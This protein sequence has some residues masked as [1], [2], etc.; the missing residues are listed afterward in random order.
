MHRLFDLFHHGA[1]LDG[2]NAQVSVRNFTLASRKI[3]PQTATLS[4]VPPPS[5]EQIAFIIS[6]LP[7]AIC[8]ADSDGMVSHT[9][10]AFDTLTG[11]H[12]DKAKGSRNV[13]D[14]ISTSA[15]DKLYASLLSL[16]HKKTSFETG[17]HI[18]RCS[19]NG[20]SELTSCSWTIAAIPSTKNLLITIRPIGDC[21]SDV[22][23]NEEGE[24]FSQIQ[25]ANLWKKSSVRQASFRVG[26][27]SSRD[28]LKS[29]TKN[30]IA[31]MERRTRERV[32][33][34]L[35][36]ESSRAEVPPSDSSSIAVN[37]SFVRQVSHEIRTPLCVIMSSLELLKSMKQ[38]MQSEIYEL[39]DDIRTAT[40]VITSTLDNLITLG[41][42]DSKSL[43]LEK[44]SFDPVGLVNSAVDNARE[45]NSSISL[46]NQVVPGTL[47]IN[48]D[49]GRLHQATRNLLSEMIHL[50]EGHASIALTQVNGGSKIRIEV[51]DPRP[52]RRD[53]VAVEGEDVEFITDVDKLK[54]HKLSFDV[55]ISKRLIEMHGGSFGIELMRADRRFKFSFEL[56][57]LQDT[58]RAVNSE[59]ASET[60]ESSR[61][62]SN[63]VRENSSISEARESFSSQ[64]YKIMIVDDAVLCRKMHSKLLKTW[65]GEM[66]EA[67]NGLE[68]VDHIIKAIS[69]GS[70]I[71]GII[72]DN[73][74][75][76][77][78]GTLATKKIRELGYQG[79][80]FGVTGN[81]LQ[82]DVD[83]FMNHGVDE[84]LIKPLSGEKYNHIAQSIIA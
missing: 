58:S 71:H 22:L 70:I 56:S 49:L 29:S 34:V 8:I 30:I 57:C 75:P 62:E 83:E 69:S 76:I 39:I 79:K 54:D 40:S 67:S 81:G 18:T 1:G 65:F 52:K 44:E 5:L 16:Q 78:P 61:V 26:E 10:L 24:L 17:I 63:S 42:I 14:M 20:K 7:S 72:M 80:I 36:E 28:S 41:E 32:K 2:S 51:I 13:F 9:N 25:V 23:S 11:Q 4:P 15:A 31:K 59:G 12:K 74:M 37:S 27:I 50:T 19:K 73:S 45:K 33:N 21:P 38:I 60:R 55:A 77:M 53:T 66:I 6:L 68:A 84:V 47:T 82:A 3:A 46:S 48:G 64:K 35:P 43:R